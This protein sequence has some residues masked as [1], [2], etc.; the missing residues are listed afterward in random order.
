MAVLADRYCIGPD[1]DHRATWQYATE[2]G[3][4]PLNPDEFVGLRLPG[5]TSRLRAFRK[6][7]ADRELRVLTSAG[8]IGGAGQGR[9]Y[10]RYCWVSSTQEDVQN[11]DRDLEAL[12]GTA[13]FRVEG[14]TRLFA[15]IPRPGGEVERVSRRLYMLSGWV[16][17][18]EQGLRQVTIRPY[19]A[20]VF[21]G[22]ASPRTEETYEGADWSGPEPVPRP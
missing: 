22:Y 14:R 18:R 3:F 12:T 20:G 19:D 10:Y 4:S 11:V 15:W 13:S 7:E 2:D 17:A 9:T 8:Y 5:F 16:L 21:V 6:L 1:G